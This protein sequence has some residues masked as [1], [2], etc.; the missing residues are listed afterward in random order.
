MLLL[1]HG[2]PGRAHAKDNICRSRWLDA[3]Q[4]LWWLINSLVR[5]SWSTASTASS[6]VYRSRSPCWRRRSLGSSTASIIAIYYAHLG[7]LCA[8][9]RPGSI[10]LYRSRWY[11]NDW[12]WLLLLLLECLICSLLSWNWIIR[13]QVLTQHDCLLKLWTVSAWAWA[14]V[15][16]R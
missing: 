3:C 6:L 11:I 2:L 4:R 10:C 5:H 1:G 7:R 16:P 8:H 12:S 9:R 15:S 13:R 14:N